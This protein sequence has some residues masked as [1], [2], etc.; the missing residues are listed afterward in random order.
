MRQRIGCRLSLLSND[1][2]NNHPLQR[3]KP[4]RP[5]KH[6]FGR[7]RSHSR[8]DSR[9]PFQEI[10][11]SISLVFGGGYRIFSKQRFLQ[12]VN[13]GIQYLQLDLSEAGL[14][15]EPTILATYAF[16]AMR[17]PLTNAVSSF[18]LNTHAE[19]VY[20]VRDPIQMEISCHENQSNELDVDQLDPEDN[21]IPRNQRVKET[22]FAGT[23]SDM[24]V[25]FP[26]YLRQSSLTRC[27]K[28]RWKHQECRLG[29]EWPL[30]TLDL[31]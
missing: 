13:S 4:Q 19:S 2:R 6:G 15:L 5:T 22:W 17:L 9:P 16:S 11:T 14:F 28:R 21:A 12:F 25:F 24:Y 3:F 23:H 8:I 1:R 30:F 18:F 26:V 29:P 27:L 10:F 20:Q 31:L 7:S